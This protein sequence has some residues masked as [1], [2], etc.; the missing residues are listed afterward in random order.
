MLF[1]V[2]QLCLT[3]CNPIDCTSPGSLVQGDFPGKNT[4]VGSLFLL[5]GIFLTPELKQGFLHCSQILYQLNYQGNP[6]CYCK[7]GT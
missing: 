4:G 3:L 1:L 5:Q 7:G 2:I 6:R